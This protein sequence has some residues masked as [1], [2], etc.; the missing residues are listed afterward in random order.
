MYAGI[1]LLK[2]RLG[3][4]SRETAKALMAR[5]F[6]GAYYKYF[7]EQSRPGTDHPQATPNTS[8]INT[9]KPGVSE[10]NS[11]ANKDDLSVQGWPWLSEEFAEASEVVISLSVPN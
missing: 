7:G 4:E 3:L 9:Q 8:S 11:Q 10:L 1:M 2:I 5:R 6:L